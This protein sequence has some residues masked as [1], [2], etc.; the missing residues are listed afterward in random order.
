VTCQYLTFIFSFSL[1]LP[2]LL[3]SL[4]HPHLTE[5]ASKLQST[6]TSSL[7][8]FSLMV[9]SL[10]LEDNFH[11]RNS[12]T[13]YS[14]CFIDPHP[15]IQKSRSWWRWAHCFQEVSQNLLLDVSR[16][17]LPN[18][19]PIAWTTDCP[20][21]SVGSW[22]HGSFPMTVNPAVLP[23]GYQPKVSD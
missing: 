5:Y 16:G 20:S 23:I 15:W 11:I 3:V 17:E 2:I 1:S 12:S 6:D 7:K 10:T 8:A 19:G 18:Y 4:P 22:P 14:R 21:K 9:S 13:V